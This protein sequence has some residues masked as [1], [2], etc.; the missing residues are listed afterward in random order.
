MSSVV[1]PAVPLP[2][3]PRHAAAGSGPGSWSV[4][5]CCSGGGSF[6]FLR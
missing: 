4:A 5:G 6:A 2:R 1:D 3:S